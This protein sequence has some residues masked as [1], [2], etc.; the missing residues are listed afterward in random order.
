WRQVL[1]ITVNPSKADARLL[2]GRDHVFSRSED[3]DIILTFFLDRDLSREHFFLEFS[4]SVL[5]FENTCG[6]AIAHLF[7]TDGMAEDEI[8]CAISE[9][10]SGCGSFV[11]QLKRML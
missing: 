8:G 6:D 7:C 3:V 9:V 11:L 2:D 10:E 1:F 5:W 4:F